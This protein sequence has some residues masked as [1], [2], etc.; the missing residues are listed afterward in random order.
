MA[1]KNE[2]GFGAIYKITNLINGKMY[3]GQTT[4]LYINNRWCE[5]K[6]NAR[7]GERSY[8]YNAIRKYGENNF[9]FKV[10]LSK[11]PIDKLDFYEQLWIKKLNTRSPN[12]YNLTD[13]GGG[14]RGFIPWDK[15]IKRSV[16]D[17]EKIKAQ[18]TPEV[19]E[20]IRQKMLGKNNPMYGKKGILNPAYGLQRFGKDNPF[21]GKTHS[22]ETK[23]KLSNAQ[24]NKKQKVAMLD[25][26]TEEIIYIF[27]SYSE[28]GK[29][30]RENT[31][32]KKADDSAISKCARGI[33][34]YVYGYK[35]RNIEL[36]NS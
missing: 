15:G 12:G 22:E 29:Y 36:F 30:L 21:Y 26:D 4:K 6:N 10:L 27:N 32:F 24:Q 23:Q 1:L 3:I 16:E 7:N 34:K 17:V 31:E 20:K 35:W 19:R 9:E 13:G 8:L 5:H 14:T 2:K 25:I 18:F 11:I 28:A 33:Y